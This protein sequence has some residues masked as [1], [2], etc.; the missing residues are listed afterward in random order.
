MLTCT[1]PSLSSCTCSALPTKPASHTRSMSLTDS[2]QAC[3][4]GDTLPALG[5]VCAGRKRI[6]HRVCRSN[7]SSRT[8]LTGSYPPYTSKL[9]S[10]PDRRKAPESSYLTDPSA[11]QVVSMASKCQHSF[12]ASK[13]SRLFSCR[14]F[15]P[16]TCT[17]GAHNEYFG[18][19]AS[20]QFHC[21]TT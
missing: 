15:H 16:C 19:V 5:D 6:S 8:L 18:Y 3:S 12:G 20:H 17:A 4:L 21:T 13:L 14:P 1:S 2:G 11:S 7:P 10:S 9:S